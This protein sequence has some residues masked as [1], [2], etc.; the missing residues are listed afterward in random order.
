MPI[1][2][3]V[4]YRRLLTIAFGS[5]ASIRSNLRSSL[6]PL[7]VKRL[8]AALGFAP[9]AQARE[10]DATQWASVFAFVTRRSPP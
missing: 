1:E 6:S 10:L 8:A 9:N 4:A 3:H 7:E 5:S 2:A